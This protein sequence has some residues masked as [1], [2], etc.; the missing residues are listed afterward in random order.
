MIKNFKIRKIHK[1]TQ[2]QI[3]KNSKP[4]K[5]PKNITEFQQKKIMF[6]FFL[7]LK[8]GK[9]FCFDQKNQIKMLFSYFFHLRRLIFDQSS[10]VHLVSESRGGVV[11][12]DEGQRTDK[13]K[14][15]CLIFTGVHPSGGP[16]TCVNCV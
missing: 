1:N 8:I 4:S 2:K 6:F 5:I 7:N 13:Q 15:L 16:E 10:P 11:E 12:L 3:K 14:F 9:Y